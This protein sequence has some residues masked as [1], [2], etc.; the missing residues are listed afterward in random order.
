MR[1]YLKYERKTLVAERVKTRW[2]RIPT[3]EK[4]K[5]DAVFIEILSYSLT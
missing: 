3:V 4:G 5:Q 1:D 2:V